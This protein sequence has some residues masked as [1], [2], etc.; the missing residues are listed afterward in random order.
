MRPMNTDTAVVP[1]NRSL[2]ER[3]EALVTHGAPGVLYTYEQ[4]TGRIEALQFV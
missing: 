3:H 4:G 1:A 2:A